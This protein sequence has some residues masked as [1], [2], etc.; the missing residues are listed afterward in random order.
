[1]QNLCNFLQYYANLCIIKMKADM[2]RDTASIIQARCRHIRRKLY[3][4]G[5]HHSIIGT[6]SASIGWMVAVN[7]ICMFAFEVLR[8]FSREYPP[9]HLPFSNSGG[10]LD[11]PHRFCKT[12]DSPQMST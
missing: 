11:R 3:I 8:S 4:T 1:M 7:I 2:D 12:L 9:A 10:S 6:Q 5:K